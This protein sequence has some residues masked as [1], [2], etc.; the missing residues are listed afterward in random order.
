MEMEKL[1]LANI[2]MFDARAE[3]PMVDVWHDL[4]TDHTVLMSELRLVLELMNERVGLTRLRVSW[5][6][7]FFNPIVLEK[8][9]TP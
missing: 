1:R 4:P 5:P 8:S 3:E 7:N 6:D 2:Q 9:P